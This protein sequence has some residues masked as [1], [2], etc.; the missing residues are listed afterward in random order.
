MT[1]GRISIE[2]LQEACERIDPNAEG[3]V[4]ACQALVDSGLT[5][6]EA[7]VKIANDQSALR[8]PVGTAGMS[9]YERLGSEKQPKAR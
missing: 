8:K 3:L 4:S 7:L 2:E 1:T 9:S 5:L 6:A